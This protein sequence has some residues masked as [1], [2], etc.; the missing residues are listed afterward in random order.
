MYNYINVDLSELFKNLKVTKYTP[1]DK[2]TSFADFSYNL[3][4]K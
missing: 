1:F 4:C 2:T 3:R